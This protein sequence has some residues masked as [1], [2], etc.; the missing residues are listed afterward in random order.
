MP[1]DPT[2]PED[3]AAGGN[4]RLET[5]IGVLDIM[6]SLSGIDDRPAYK[7]LKADARRAEACGTVS[8]GR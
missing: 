8:A 3:L 6:Q 4:F 5:S 7:T 1:F 2:R